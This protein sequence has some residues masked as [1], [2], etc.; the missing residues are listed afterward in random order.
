MEG[1]NCKKGM[2]VL[3]LWEIKRC[4][5]DFVEKGFEENLSLSG[6]LKC[7]DL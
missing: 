2:M 3:V 7:E 4:I 5:L 6:I 1:N